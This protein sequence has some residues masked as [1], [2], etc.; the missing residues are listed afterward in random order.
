MC[1]RS[2]LLRKSISTW[3]NSLLSRRTNPIRLWSP[4]FLLPIFSQLA[5]VS[6]GCTLENQWSTPNF[7]HLLYIS[8]VMI[9]K[10]R[11]LR[12]RRSQL[13]LGIHPISRFALFVKRGCDFGIKQR[14]RVRNWTGANSVDFS[15]SCGFSIH[16][17][18]QERRLNRCVKLLGRAVHSFHC[19]EKLVCKWGK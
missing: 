9:R 12:S 7:T 5:C 3:W 17:S 14:Q 4:R 6:L 15:N 11:I 10:L 1:S 8:Q 2:L 18:P 16:I 19:C 13:L